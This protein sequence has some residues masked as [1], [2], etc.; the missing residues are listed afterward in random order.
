MSARMFLAVL[1]FECRYQSRSPLFLVVA[2][3]F[4]LL[5]FLVMASESVSVGGIGDNLNLNANFAILQIQYTFSILGM[6]V[7]VAFVASAITRD[8]EA[9][10]AE[11]LFATGVD[12]TSYLLGRFAGGTLFALLAM[13]VGLLGTLIGSLMPWL[14]PDRLGPF[15][16]AL[17]LFSLWAV[18][19][20][21][22]LVICALFF[23]VAA[24]ARSML[25]A[26]VT[27][28]GFMI[29]YIVLASVTDQETIGTMALADPFG[30]VAFGEITRYWTV[31]ERNFAMPAFTDTLMV[32]RLIWAGVAVFVL[33]LT[34]WRYRFSLLPSWFRWPRR[35][36]RAGRPAPPGRVDVLRTSA[37][38]GSTVARLISQLRMDVRGMT[39]SV[40]FYVLLAF[41]MMQVIGSYIGAAT[42]LFGTPV[43]PVTGLLVQVVGGSF[44]LAVLIII[45]YYSGELVHRERQ[46]QVQEIIDATPFPDVVMVL[47]KIGALWFVITALLIVVMVTSIAV[48]W[49]MDYHRHEPMLYVRS[50]FGVL[51]SWY[52]LLCVPAVL[53]QV[54]SPNKLLGM[55]VFL[56]VFLGLVTLPSLDF[57]H[58]LY[59]Y[60]V[61]TAPYSDMNGY[62]HFILPL[63]SIALYWFL[64]AG[65]LVV[66]AHLLQTRGYVDGLSGR[67]KIARTR[68]NRRVAAVSMVLLAGFLSAG[69]WIFYNTNMLND[70]L[71][72]DDRDMARADYEK[73]YKGLEAE[74]RPEVT[75]IEL[76]VELYPDERRLVSR[77]VARLVNHTDAPI[78]TLHFSVSPLLTIDVLSLAGGELVAEDV[79]L[80]YRKFQ[81]ESPLA[82]GASTELRWE[83][84]WFNKGFPNT[85]SSTRVVANGTFVNNTEIMPLPG[86]FSGRE[87][88]DNNVRRR[89]D[90][91]P[92]ERL[93]RLG[94]PGHLGLSQFGVAQ[95]TGFR[96]VVSTSA[97]QI[98]IAPGYLVSDVTAGDR[99]T[100]TYEMDAP[101]WPFVSIT[102]ARYA[103]AE[104]HWGDVKLEVYYHP[105]HDFNVQRMITG[106]KRSLDYF[107]REFSPYQ[108]R[109]FRI[110]EFPAYEM[111]AQ[112]F[113][114]TIPFSEGIGF[115]ADLRDEKSIDYVF[116]V[117]A[118]EMAHQ[119]WGHQVVGAQMQGM[120]LMVETLAQ[121][122]A[123]MVMKAEYGEHKMRRFLK[124]E[125]D[126][127]LQGRGGELIEEQP[128]LK[129]ENQGYVHYR[130]GSLAMYALQDAIG[131]D[132]VNAA[133]RSFIA[134][135]G[136][137]ENH[138]PMSTD[139]IDEFRLVA[140]EQHQQLITDLFEKIVLYDL[141]VSAASVVQTDAGYEIEMTVEARKF[142]A[143]G[144]G[145]ETEVPLSQMLELAVF[146]VKPDELGDEDLPEPVLIVRE[147]IRSG[148]QTFRF[149]VSDAPV[150]VGI[151]PFVKMIDRN[152][153]DN[154]RIL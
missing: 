141:K 118:H 63:V 154:I 40:P 36:A 86:Y 93:P 45:I 33:L 67:L 5:E 62:G 120:T 3:L 17:Y 56:A 140:D 134:R 135:F 66:A 28:L 75:D 90:L 103:V 136:F 89:Y 64:F 38:P 101:I 10:T 151:D 116:Y 106:S 114:N 91:P 2:A 13:I 27:A 145:E 99:R 11:L 83:F 149:T 15:D 150:R 9:Q 74:P 137:S 43:Y 138:F 95:R 84:T 105:T 130:K 20:P 47:A 23:A 48:Q 82:P 85:G 126:R 52:Y 16:L 65:L 29:V 108:Y 94:D 100:F 131:E 41:G 24:L 71:T 68:W 110:I 61:P 53:I 80:G 81:L 42:Q 55:V 30:I 146:P 32:N 50:L 121:Y 31:F 129:V 142:E 111:F 76:S 132:R 77:G 88:E 133:L 58:F 96:A 46:A 8:Y 19:L 87:L 147:V 115:I 18:I 54:M 6:F 25:A 119:W 72:S 35:A 153:D 26:Y 144:A 127:Y 125:L 1:S 122:W 124:Y 78:A 34:T 14:D 102:S 152:P 117:T 70:Y 123:L 60:A 92:L 37:G 139:L 112:S 39:R 79:R 97:D 51:G 148:Q 104:D 143:D 98:A 109:Q 113:P 44:S 128:L 4:F 59:R 69:G 107:T 57:E 7:A 21:N 12:E 49:F 22:L 73:A